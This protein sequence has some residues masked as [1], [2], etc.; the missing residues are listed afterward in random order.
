M[1][2]AENLLMCGA[3]L[4]TTLVRFAIM[5]IY[6]RRGWFPSLVERM[7]TQPRSNGL[8]LRFERWLVKPIVKRRLEERK[9][10]NRRTLYD[11]EPHQPGVYPDAST[12]YH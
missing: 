11:M 5:T 8:Q 10:A 6:D 3:V 2:F 4:F 7:E 9:R 1:V 12:T